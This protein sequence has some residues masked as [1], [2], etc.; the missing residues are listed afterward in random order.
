TDADV[1]WVAASEYVWIN[2][3]VIQGPRWRV[4]ELGGT[5]GGSGVDCIS[6]S[7][8]G[9]NGCRATNCVLINGTHCGLKEQ[10]HGGTN[11]LVEANV[12]IYNGMTGLDHG[13]YFPCEDSTV[14]GNI[15]TASAGYGMHTYAGS[16]PDPNDPNGPWVRHHPSGLLI[17]RNISLQDPISG[18]QNSQSLLTGLNNE[19]YN[20][21]LVGGTVGFWFFGGEGGTGNKVYNNIFAHNSSTSFG[22]NG[23][24]QET[25]EADYN[26]FYPGDANDEGANSIT[27]D[28][29]FNGD[30]NDANDLDF[31]LDAN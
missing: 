11:I 21:V 20:N 17:T 14:N 24:D 15:F 9:G 7:N 5:G 29:Q 18:R 8:S 12:G 22:W 1:A 13:I 30:A 26:A 2:G 16:Q 28:P 6:W 4:S 31:S 27:G 19:M 3:L 10:G 25:N 23:W